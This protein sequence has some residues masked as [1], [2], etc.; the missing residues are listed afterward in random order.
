M[1]LL[2][3]VIV[4][5]IIAIIMVVAVPNV[6]NI[7]NNSKDQAA[8]MQARGILT[9][10][11]SYQMA[12]GHYPSESQGLKALVNKPTSAPIPK[13]WKQLEETVPVDPWQNEYIYKYDS[14]SAFP[15]I[16]SK[17]QDGKLG[18]DDDISS[19]DNT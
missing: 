18:T 15:E 12:A 8:Q 16:I 2:E 4:L 5:A 17:G 6:G 7:L 13:R 10:L 19:K 3:I 1:T 9:T 11:T 14:S